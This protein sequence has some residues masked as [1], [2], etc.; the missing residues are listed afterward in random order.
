MGKFSLLVE[1][2]IC[3][4]YTVE[5]YDEGHF[6]NNEISHNLVRYIASIFRPLTCWVVISS[7]RMPIV[8]GTFTSS[9]KKL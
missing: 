5:V 9:A 4:Q 8:L 7:R 6:D 2:A 1:T 3:S